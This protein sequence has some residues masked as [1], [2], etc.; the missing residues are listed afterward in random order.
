MKVSIITVTYNSAATLADTL[1]SVRRQDYPDVEHILVDGA[2]KDETV[3]IIKSYPHVKKWVSEKDKGLYDAI[4]KGI[5]MASGDVVG[6]LNSDDFFPNSGVV[7]TIARAFEE[8]NIDAVY[9]DIA[10]VR[11]ENLGKIVRLY[12]SRKF[13]PRRFAYGYMPAHP[14]FY[15]RKS[16][17]EQMGLYK[18]DYTIAADYEL[19]MRFIYRYKIPYYYIPETLVYMRTGGVSNKN[20]L[21]RYTLNREIIRACKENNVNTNMAILSIKYLNKMFEYIGP[22]LKRT[23]K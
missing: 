21:S 17:F 10:F 8:N 5:L 16:C 18:P 11:P 20:I 14:S 13:T 3:N 6:I 22:A 23:R 12:S 7:S 4:N 2:S 1:D 15:A 9:G 19:L